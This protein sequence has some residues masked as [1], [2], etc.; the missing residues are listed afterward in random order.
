M[1]KLREQEYYK[2]NDSPRA[3]PPFTIYQDENFIVITDS[4]RLTLPHSGCWEG[5]PD[6]DQEASTYSGS[7]LSSIDSM[8]CSEML[9]VLDSGLNIGETI[10]LDSMKVGYFND[11][12][13][14]SENQD[15]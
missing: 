4:F 3:L 7:L 9:I 1:I 12:I 14:P 8:N 11:T 15:V 13:Y 6:F 2:L 10:I 5:A